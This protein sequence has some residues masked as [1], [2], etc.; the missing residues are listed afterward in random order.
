MFITKHVSHESRGFELIIVN[1]EYQNA[2]YTMKRPCT[3]CL[4]NMINVFKS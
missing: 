2:L 3:L 1:D 4:I